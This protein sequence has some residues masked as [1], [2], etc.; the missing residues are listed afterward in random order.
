MFLQ[1]GFPSLSQLTE[2]SGLLEEELAKFEDVF[3]LV[4]LRAD[5]MAVDVESHLVRRHM[6]LM[7]LSDALEVGMLETLLDCQPKERVEY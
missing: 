2:L 6:L 1:V 3:R 7:Y 5:I 4:T